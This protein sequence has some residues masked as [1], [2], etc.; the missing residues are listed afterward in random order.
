MVRI[1]I[2]Q[3]IIDQMYKK[4]KDVELLIEENKSLG[5]ENDDYFELPFYAWECITLLHKNRD[6]D[7]VIRNESQM[8]IFLLYLIKKLNTHNGYINSI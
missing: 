1:G 5:S 8:Q 2:N 6:I 7:L 4:R 3:M